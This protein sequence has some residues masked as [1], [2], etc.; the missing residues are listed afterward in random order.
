MRDLGRWQVWAGPDLTM[1]NNPPTPFINEVSSFSMK[2]IG[3]LLYFL[4][5]LRN[6]GRRIQLDFDLVGWLYE[7]WV[8]KYFQWQRIFSLLDIVT[9]R[10]WLQQ[11]LCD[12]IA[13]YVQTWHCKY[14]TINVSIIY[15]NHSIQVTS[16]SS[17]FL[18]LN[19]SWS[20]LSSIVYIYLRYLSVEKSTENIF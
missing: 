4:E 5:T 6:L 17:H 8:L 13:N 11:L 9:I 1:S 12:I 19:T 7:V 16:R 18:N 15:S 20:S 2:S 10:T 14:V 3:F